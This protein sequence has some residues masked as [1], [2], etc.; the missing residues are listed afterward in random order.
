MSEHRATVQWQNHGVTLDYENFSR[1][2]RW[3]V[4]EGRLTVPA[5]SAPAYKGNPDVMDPEDALVAALASCHMLTFLAIAA[6]RRLV[7]LDYTDSAQGWLEPD[8]AGRL[9]V[10]RVELR[11]VVRFAPG[12]VLSVEE[13]GKLHEK[14]HRGCFIANSLKTAVTVIP[15]KVPDT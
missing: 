6:R 13:H 1:D 14:A 15:E 9:A 7:V 12:T 5:S 3:L 10:T 11:P 4:K 8:A 2:H